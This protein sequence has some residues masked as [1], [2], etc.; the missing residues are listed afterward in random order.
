VTGSLSRCQIL[1]H[2][3]YVQNRH[4]F[5]IFS[6]TN[7]EIKRCLESCFWYYFAKFFALNVKIC[8]C[9]EHH[10]CSDKEVIKAEC[11]ATVWVVPY[12]SYRLS[13]LVQFFSP[14]CVYF[15]ALSIL[16]VAT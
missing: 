12:N 3:T 2:L 14:P 9:F 1:P 5:I 6:E 10:C 15:L 7:K 13:K 11:G 4:L 16:G 8:G